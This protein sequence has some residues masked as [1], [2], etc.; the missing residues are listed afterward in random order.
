VIDRAFEQ[1]PDERA[2]REH[3]ASA[4]FQ[5]GVD[6]GRWHL[7][8]LS[9]PHAIIAVSAAPRNAAPEEFA[10]RFELT[11]YPPVA[12]TANPWDCETNSLLSASRRP[13]GDRVG[14]VFQSDQLY[15]PWDR[16]GLNSHSEWAQSHPRYA[17]NQRRDLTFYLAN[18]FDLL[19]D[20][21]YL[22]V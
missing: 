7:I 13:K 18:V 17:W 21:D 4:R 3:L 19:N 9:W 8:S 1:A 15:A 22:G 12:P 14:R 10:L 5:A 2:L 20:D 6:A 11:G 16:A